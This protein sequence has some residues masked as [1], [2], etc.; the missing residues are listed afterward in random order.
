[1][2]KIVGIMLVMFFVSFSGLVNAQT[3]VV[4]VEESGELPTKQKKADRIEKRLAKM[5][6]SLDLSEAQAIEI[7]S[8]MEE[9]MEAIG[10]AKKKRRKNKQKN[11]QKKAEYRAEMNAKMKTILSEEQYIKYL[12]MRK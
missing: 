8:L 1:M 9:K 10:K 12:E 6:E 5:T 4:P 3:D 11:K 7:R 2:K